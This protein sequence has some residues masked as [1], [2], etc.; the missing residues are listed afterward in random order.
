MT[1][2]NRRAAL[3]VLGLGG[4]ALA[5]CSAA[6][7][8][9]LTAAD[10]VGK[11]S[12]A[13]KAVK[14]VHFSLVAT[15]GSMVIGGSLPA[16]DLEG[17]VLR[18]DRI[19][20]TA[21]SAFGNVTVKIGFVIVGPKEYVTNPITKQWQAV[22]GDIAAP[23]LLDPQQGAGALLQKATELKKLPDASV[24]GTDC[25]HLSG[26]LNSTLIAGL[27]GSKGLDTS[28]ASEVWIG[29]SDFLV[30]QIK[31]LGPITAEEPPAI[32]R[33]LALSDFNENVTIDP[34]A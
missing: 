14:S 9:A 18:P 26:Q 28:L 5:A 1:T 30:R 7:P 21:T 32:Q 8:P 16:K 27:L 31:L 13:L 25:Y 22:P 4:F 10:I 34:P 11:A 15:G 2:L 19:K 12:D 23:N 20:G 17:D 29:K 24:D 3:G 33:V 6:K